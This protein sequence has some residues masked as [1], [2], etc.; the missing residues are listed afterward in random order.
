[1]ALKLLSHAEQVA[2]H[3]RTALL[4]RRWT[5]T[6]PGVL[7]L[8][9]E[10]GVNRT[11]V[12]TA[13]QLLE[14]EGLLIPRG[15]GKPRLISIPGDARSPGTRIGILRFEP[16]ESQQ[17]EMVDLLHRLREDGHEIV[18][19]PKT[20]SGM[21]MET[22]KVKRL[23]KGIA[24]DGWVVVCAE[25]HILRWFAEQPV[26]F[27]AYHGRDIPGLPMAR[28]GLALEAALSEMLRRLISLGHRRIV[29]L[30]QAS[31][32]SGL[33]VAEMKAAGIETGPYHHP[34]LG[35]GP[36]AFRR[37]LDSLFAMT[38]PTALYIDEAPL[39][40]AAMSHLARKGIHAPRDVSLA[41]LGWHP[42]FGYVEPEVSRVDW[43]GNDIVNRV[44]RWARNV[45]RKHKDTA[46][47]WVK[48][49]FI[50][51][52]SIGPPP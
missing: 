2:E 13:L 28:V 27:I 43:D 3:L 39:T 4:R 47:T 9:A 24:V 42:V 15:V 51:G 50:E 1:M 6:M 22:E 44:L 49:T 41:C 25:D 35:P 31:R 46:A 38:P 7:A 10:L 14:R 23:V 29:S 34:R 11:T 37:T 5:G 40:L 18:V 17:I 16:Q 8:Q 30:S 21:G 26:P 36:A 32:P 48:S 20:L 52:G 33:F 45:E 12:D 19:A